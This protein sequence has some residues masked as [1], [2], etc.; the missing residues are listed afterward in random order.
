ML[1]KSITGFNNSK[2]EHEDYNYDPLYCL[3]LVGSAHSR[4]GNGG[5][6]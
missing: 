5:G 2:L 3:V 6:F 4:N 1:I